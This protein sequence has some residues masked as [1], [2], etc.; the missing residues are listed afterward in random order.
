M[1]YFLRITRPHTG[2]LLTVPSPLPN[3]GRVDEMTSQYLN[4]FVDA[5]YPGF[6]IIELWT[7]DQ[8]LMFEEKVL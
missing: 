7:S 4:C 8:K 5:N 2:T 3:I 6:E 1:K